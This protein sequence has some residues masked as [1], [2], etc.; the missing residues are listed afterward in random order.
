MTG[1]ELRIK[2]EAAGMSRTELGR[3]MGFT[4]TP[5]RINNRIYDY[6]VQRRNMTPAIEILIQLIL[7]NHSK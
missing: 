1:Q 7:E 4:G 5:R 3:Q 2:R 6:E